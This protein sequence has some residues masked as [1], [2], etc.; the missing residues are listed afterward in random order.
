[1]SSSSVD[2]RR[3]LPRS[4]LFA[5]AALLLV[6][7]ALGLRTVDPA[8]E[9]GVVE[10]P[11][12]TRFRVSGGWTLAP[13]GLFSLSRYPV[14]GIELALPQ[15]EQAMLRASDGSRYGFRGWATLRVRPDAWRELHAAAGGEGLDG[16]LTGAVRRASEGADIVAAGGLLTPTLARLVEQRLGDELGAAGVDL[17]RLELLAIDFLAVPEGTRASPTGARLLVV[18]LDGADWA[19]LDPLMEQGRMPHLK[20]LIERGVRAKLLSVSPL[21]S[22]VIWTTVATGV[23]PSRHGIL[24]FLVE[25][26]E[27][28]ERQPVTSAQ[29][30]VP[31]VWEILSRS[32]VEVGVVGWWASWPADPVRGYLVSDRI[33]YQLFGFRSDPGRAQ[34]KT[35]PPDLYGDIRPRILSP[36]SVGWDRIVPYLSGPRSREEEFD[37]EE[38]ELLDGMRTLVASGETYLGLA[39]ELR[40]RFRPQLEVV[41]FEGTDTVG[42]LFMP[43]RPPPLPG[44]DPDRLQSF[45]AMVDR[46]YETADQYLGRLLEDRDES[47]TVMILSD[48]GFANDASRPRSTDSR[49]GHGAAADWHRRFGILVLSG[50]HV[51]HAGSVDEATVYDI[52]PTILALFGQPIP[53]SWP[54]KVLGQALKAEFVDEHPVR[55]RTDDPPREQQVGGDTP[56]DPDAAELIAKLRNLGYISSGG[57]EGDSVSARNNAGVAYLS[58]GR[59]ADAERE[60]RAG[61]VAA[62]GAPMLRFNLGMAL[63]MQGRVDEASRLFEEVLDVPQTLRMAGHM[64]AQI[65]VAEGN[66]PEAERLLRQVLTREP[67]AAEIRNALGRVLELAGDGEGARAEYLHATELDPDTALARNNLGNLAKQEGRDAEAESWYLRAIEANPYFMGAYNNLALVYQE[68]G[69]MEKA[70]DLYDRALAKAPDNAELLNNVGSWY[71]ATGDLEQARRLWTRAA[72]AAPEYPSPLNNLAGMAINAQRYDEADQLLR[73][74]IDLDPGYGDARINMAILL[75]GRGDIDGARAQ[76]RLAVEDPRARRTAWA[77]LGYLELEQGYVEEALQALEQATRH[78]PRD[79]HAW[80]AWGEAHRRLGRRDRALE[81][82]RH[83]LGLEPNQ[84]Q[85]EASIRALEDEAAIP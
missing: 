15:A 85:L 71:Y 27:T 37:D 73:R 45:S 43:Y 60:F 50:A 33:A 54:G 19:I 64:L 1:M 48:H 80:N 22:P 25:D 14:R 72:A 40:G 82:W 70:L 58:E 3:R 57:E 21:L 49:I 77:Q 67:D 31:T 56:V 75:R 34:G 20:R 26:P 76:L 11:L 7:L 65:R 41:Y 23:E 24:D 42:H 13:P 55:F 69:Q 44:V 66:L 68:R 84:P 8:T 9:L 59:Y 39:R 46:Y 38:R 52:A 61:L 30:N 47:W 83:S 2:R 5:A 62:P 36:E 29:R 51:D 32:G 28:G 18:G 35:W 53:R 10:G 12:G 81:I 74:A 17:R 6:W 16:V 79:I 4:W 63:R 78:A